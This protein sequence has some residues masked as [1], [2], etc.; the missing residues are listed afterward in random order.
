MYR[1]VH[2]A[3]FI[4]C[5]TDVVEVP[6]RQKLCS[7]GAAYWRVDKPIGC[8]GAGGIEHFI[9][10]RHRSPASQV[11]I[12][13][14]SEEPLKKSFS[15]TMLAHVSIFLAFRAVKRVSRSKETNRLD[16][17]PQHPNQ[18]GFTFRINFTLKLKR[19]GE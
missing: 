18:G 17:L 4:G 6:S 16:V 19:K 11:Q 3:T 7:A 8:S 1:Y 15:Q 13:V 12:L 10:L 9:S 5:L 14:I 2:A